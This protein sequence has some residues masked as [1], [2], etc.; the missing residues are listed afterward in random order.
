LGLMLIGAPGTDAKT[1][2]I[3]KRIAPD[4]ELPR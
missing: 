4:I 2:A 3:A 1:A